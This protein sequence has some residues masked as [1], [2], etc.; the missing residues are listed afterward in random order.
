MDIWSEIPVAWVLKN[1]EGDKVGKVHLVEDGGW[2]ME[3]GGWRMEVHLLKTYR[4]SNNE[5]PSSV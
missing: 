2:R 4:T 5:V 3:D 1:I